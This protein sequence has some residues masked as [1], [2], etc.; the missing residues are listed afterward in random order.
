MFTS[1]NSYNITLTPGYS[2]TNYPE[3]WTVWIDFNGDGDFTDSGEQVFSSN[4]TSTSA[5][6][7]T[8]NIPGST[9]ITTRMRIS[10]KYNAAPSSC[11]SFN[12]GEVEDY[13]MVIVGGG[14]G[15]DTGSA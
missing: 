14:G 13:S 3:W 10:M 12:Y 15:G 11:E 7:G 9:N 6:N 2:G 8:I 5:V 4:G 1:G